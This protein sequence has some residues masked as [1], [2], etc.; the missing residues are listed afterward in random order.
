MLSNICEVIVL[1]ADC[2]DAKL[3]VK[4]RLPSAPPLTKTPVAPAT[5]PKP[6]LLRDAVLELNA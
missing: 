2:G 5:V 6:L 3:S 4:L 1:L